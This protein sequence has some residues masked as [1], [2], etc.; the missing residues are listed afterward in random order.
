M[1]NCER[2]RQKEGFPNFKFCQRTVFFFFFFFFFLKSRK[3]DVLDGTYELS[4]WIPDIDNS[5]ASN[6][7]YSIRLANENT[8]E[9]AT[10][11]NKLLQTVTLSNAVLFED[12]SDNNYSEDLSVTDY[13]SI[14]PNASSSLITL[15][16]ETSST[17]TIQIFNTVG[18][19]VKELTI[20][21]NYELD[22]SDFKKG[23]YFVRLNKNK[24]LT[25]KVIKL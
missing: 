11:Y 5:L 24:D 15:E 1:F 4:L 19:L 10:G 14:Y 7:D 9:P 6:P 20:T 2:R 12:F 17:A 23:V 8:W 25:H 21:D 18:Q 22:I 13:F 16:L 3:P